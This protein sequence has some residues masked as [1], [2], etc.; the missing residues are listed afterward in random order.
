MLKDGSDL[1][2]AEP[3]T[4]DFKEM[5]EG[6]IDGFHAGFDCSTW[7]RARFNQWDDFP[8]SAAPLRTREFPLVYRVIPPRNRL[9]PTRRH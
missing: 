2:T 5:M 3:Y 8:A 6:N 9:T 4:S 7:T 1:T